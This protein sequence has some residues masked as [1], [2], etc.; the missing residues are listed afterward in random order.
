MTTQSDST[1][2][3]TIQRDI[4]LERRPFAAIGSRV[5]LSEEDVIAKIQCLFDTGTA[6]RIGGVFDVRGVGYRSALCGA[7]VPLDKLEAAAAAITP[8]P[9][10]THCYQRGWPEELAADLPEAPPTGIPNL[11]F[12]LAAQG[13]RF[14]ATVDSIRERLAPA[15]L[16]V[17][18]AVRHFKIDVVF[19]TRVDGEQRSVEPAPQPQPPCAAGKQ[20]LASRRHEVTGEEENTAPVFSEADKALV[21]AMQGL[22]PL[23][24]SPYDDIARELGRDP[25]EILECLRAWKQAGVLRR[26]GVILRHRKMGFSANGMCVWQAGPEIVEAAGK[27]L[28]GFREVTHCYQREAIEGFPFNLFAMTHA[29]AYEAA[30]ARYHELSEAAGLESGCVLFS[31][32][33]FKKTSPRYFCENEA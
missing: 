1:W 31:L 21:R 33:E 2:M 23:V 15:P 12:T 30:L 9:G 6:R 7:T 14:E 25:D 11:W 28:A 20:D 3:T 4:P 5:D 32:K 27:T 13:E 8:E 17:M 24:P 22:I 10:M 18:P 19:D 16:F 26:V 29:G